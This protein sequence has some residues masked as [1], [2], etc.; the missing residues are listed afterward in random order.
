MVTISLKHS[1]ES[2]LNPELCL[3]FN[4][5]SSNMPSNLHIAGHLLL[6]NPA[7]GLD[8]FTA[9]ALVPLLQKESSAPVVSTLNLSQFQFAEVLCF[10]T[11]QPIVEALF[12]FSTVFPIHLPLSF[13]SFCQI[14]GGLNV[15]QPGIWV[16]VCAK[17]E[18]SRLFGWFQNL[19]S[20]ENRYGLS[21]N[22]NWSKNCISFPQQGL[23]HEVNRKAS[24]FS[25]LQIVYY[26]GDVVG[27]C[28]QWNVRFRNRKLTGA[29]RL[30]P[31]PRPTRKSDD[32]Q[33]FM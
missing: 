25:V 27:S 9:E 15:L 14:H 12:L 30:S 22:R 2:S 6:V 29:F 33:S 31:H 5:I 20:Q 3:K 1:L 23:D 4:I 16:L 7:P 17:A 11:L 26:P 10:K 28:D 24:L 21:I 8:L 19:Q 18:A 13:P 32:F